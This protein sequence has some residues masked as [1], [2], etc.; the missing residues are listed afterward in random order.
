MCL[1]HTTVTHRREQNWGMHDKR[2]IICLF[3]NRKKNMLKY[4][5]QH[6]KYYDHR[7]KDEY[8]TEYIPCRGIIQ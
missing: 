7:H 2:E 8:T 1:D 3:V 5:S 4:D 6:G